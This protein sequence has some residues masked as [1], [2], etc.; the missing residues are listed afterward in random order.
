MT[1][2]SYAVTDDGIRLFVRRI[3][4][5]PRTLVVPNGIPLLPE[6]AC[7][8]ATHTV[9]AFDPRNRGASDA[10]PDEAR[11][12]RGVHH[13]VDDIEAVRRHLGVETIDLLGHSYAGLLVVLYALQHPAQ[14]GRL[15]QI[16][17][18]PPDGHRVYPRRTDDD[19]V[20]NEV[21]AAM[22]RLHAAP[23]VDPVEHCRRMWAALCPTY[24]VDPA[25][26]ARLHGWARCQLPNERTARDHVLGRILPSVQRI[27][28]TADDLVRVSVPVL[29]IHGLRDR[30]AP[31]EGAQ[32]WVRLLPNA[33]LLSIPDAGHMPWIEAPSIV[34][35][36]VATFF[37]GA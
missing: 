3:D 19:R 27:A 31:P 8:A 14:A 5:G 36:A 21:L 34:H 16:G 13:E 20:V 26:A 18:V 11:L 6:L 12:T 9:V 22:G 17:S 2:D 4:G 32:D 24:V 7:L 10:V 23:L 33:R 29:T 25:D 30:S 28:L 35:R 37:A 15:V 1:T